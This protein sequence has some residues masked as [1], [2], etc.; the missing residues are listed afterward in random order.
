MFTCFPF[1]SSKYHLDNLCEKKMQEASQSNIT[2]LAGGLDW[3]LS[4]LCQLQPLYLK[5]A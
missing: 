5:H 1:S 2:A 3:R 4:R